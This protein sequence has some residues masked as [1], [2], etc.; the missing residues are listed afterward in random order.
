MTNETSTTETTTAA[1]AE[2]GANVAPK[3]AAPKKGTSPKKSTRKAAKE[4]AQPKKA[5]KA[6]TKTAKEPRAPREH[7]KTATVIALLSRK[8]GATLAEIAKATEWQ[9]HSI[10]GFISGTLGKKMGLKV[11]STKNQSGERVYQIAK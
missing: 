2:K 7:S 8:D 10:R 1:I 9:N 6:P 5:S 3:K 11:E 4:G